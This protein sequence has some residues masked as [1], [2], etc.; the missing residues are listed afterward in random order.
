MIEMITFLPFKNEILIAIA[1]LYRKGKS[2]YDI[3]HKIKKKEGLYGRE[4]KRK[5]SR[6]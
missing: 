6:I 4:R 3:L 5:K 2:N 1:S